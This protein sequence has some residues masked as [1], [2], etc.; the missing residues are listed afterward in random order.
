[1]LR[2]RVGRTGVAG[3][4]VYVYICDPRSHHLRGFRLLRAS[5]GSLP[6][7][8]LLKGTIALFCTVFFQR[9]QQPQQTE[10]VD[11]VSVLKYIAK[12]N[13]AEIYLDTNW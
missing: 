13:H 4:P 2:T 7:G 11:F 12:A 8:M 10:Q 9:V 3:Y 5:P 1:M 6:V